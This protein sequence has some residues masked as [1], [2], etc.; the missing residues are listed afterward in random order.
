M[1][2]KMNALIKMPLID[3]RGRAIGPFAPVSGVSSTPTRALPVRKS[4]GGGPTRSRS[5]LTA[6]LEPDDI[7]NIIVNQQ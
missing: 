4:M 5:A 2:N 7:V 6:A 1:T 3:G